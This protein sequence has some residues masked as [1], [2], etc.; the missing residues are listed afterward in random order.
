[1]TEIQATDNERLRQLTIS[2]PIW[3]TNAALLLSKTSPPNELVVR[4]I[5]FRG[6]PG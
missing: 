4:P 3:L 2:A 6:N 1:M 5:S